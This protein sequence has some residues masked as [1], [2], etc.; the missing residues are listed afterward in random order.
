MEN[1]KVK[2]TYSKGDGIR[3]ELES[4]SFDPSLTKELYDFYQDQKE[5]VKNIFI[6]ASTPIR[7][8]VSF[9]QLLYFWRKKGIIVT[10]EASIEEEEQILINKLNLSI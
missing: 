8:D 1:T 10:C 3:Y 4:T 2:Y 5:P 6:C 9:I 7:P